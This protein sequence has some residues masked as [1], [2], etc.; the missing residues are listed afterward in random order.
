MNSDTNLMYLFLIQRVPAFHALEMLFIM[1]YRNIFLT[2]LQSTFLKA[3]PEQNMIWLAN[4][5]P[6]ERVMQGQRDNVT[7]SKIVVTKKKIHSYRI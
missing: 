6:L 1:I 4:T 3:L 7:R 2:E 5:I